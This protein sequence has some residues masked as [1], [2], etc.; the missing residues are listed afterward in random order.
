[1]PEFRDHRGRLLAAEGGRHVPFGVQ[2]I[3]AISD[4]PAGLARGGH[5]HRRQEQF[6]IMLAGSCTITAESADS[7]SEENL[8]APTEGLYVPAGVWLELRDF[9][10]GAICLVLASGPFDEADYI[11]DYSAFKAGIAPAVQARR[12]GSGGQPS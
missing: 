12:G 9:S 8:V 6:L 3:F 10:P 11:R 4:V 5:A 7:S 1:L 2:R